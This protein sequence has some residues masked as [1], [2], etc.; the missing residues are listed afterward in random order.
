[1]A[2]CILYIIGTNHTHSHTKTKHLQAVHLFYMSVFQTPEISLIAD[3]KEQWRQSQRQIEQV[4]TI[5]R[6]ARMK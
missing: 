3:V 2:I 4:E 6:H 1:M 5:V